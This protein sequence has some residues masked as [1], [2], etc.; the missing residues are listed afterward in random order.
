MHAIRSAGNDGLM[1]SEALALDR[2]QSDG[3]IDKSRRI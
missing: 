1:A 3:S 2:I